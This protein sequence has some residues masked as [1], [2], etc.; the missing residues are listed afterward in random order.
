MNKLSQLSVALAT[1]STLGL[2]ACEG[3]PQEATGDDVALDDIALEEQALV[4]RSGAGLYPGGQIRAHMIT[5]GMTQA[6]TTARRDREHQ[7]RSR[8]VP[9]RLR[10]RL[11]ESH[12]RPDVDLLRQPRPGVGLLLAS[13]SVTSA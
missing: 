12:S 13:G 3:L 4:Q 8:H 2:A 9:E 1:A 5:Q 10:H 7:E 11:L 6:E